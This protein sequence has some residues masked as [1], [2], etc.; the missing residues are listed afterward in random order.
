MTHFLISFLLANFP[1]TPAGP[2]PAPQKPHVA[3]APLV[4]T[5]TATAP[6]P[7]AKT[8][9]AVL[10]EVQ[11]FYASIS[12]VTA[13]FRQSVTNE[14]YG[15]TKTSDGTVWIMKP[16]KMRWDYLETKKT[17]VEV[18]KSFISNGTYLYVVEHDNMQ[19]MKKN[20]QQ[21]LMPVAVSFL[22]GKGNLKEEF[23]PDFDTTGKYGAKG[24]LV[25]K[26]TPKKP[27]AQ[28]KNLFLV[29]DATDYHVT[30]SV[31][32]DSSNN[33]NHFRFFAPDF[34]KPIKESWFEFD[35]KSVKSYRIVDADQPQGAGSGS[36]PAKKP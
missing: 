9:A 15:T 1:G 26:L 18:K 20:L 34:K 10:D 36:A 30:Q 21:D 13:Q 17:K 6:A 11:K 5:P 14:M 25:L 8:P 23:N 3:E 33:V 32:V 2:A 29:V 35:E 22:Y 28:Y 24:E 7:T 4:A 16:G 12:Q 27:S 19:V 31:I